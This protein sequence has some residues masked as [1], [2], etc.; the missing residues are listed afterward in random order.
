MERKIQMLSPQSI[1][2]DMLEESAR[3][4]LNMGQD[5]DYVIL[6]SAE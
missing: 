2:V 3:S 6:E 4:M 1:D 5:G